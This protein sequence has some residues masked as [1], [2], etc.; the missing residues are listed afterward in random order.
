[1]SAC[2]KHWVSEM[3][4]HTIH[5]NSRKGNGCTHRLYTVVGYRCR[6]LIRYR[7][8]IL[9]YYNSS[10][11]VVSPTCPLVINLLAMSVKLH[12]DKLEIAFSGFHRWV[13]F[14]KFFFKICKFWGDAHL[15]FLKFPGSPFKSLGLTTKT[16]AASFLCFADHLTKYSTC[17]VVSFFIPQIFDII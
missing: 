16:I 10:H 3:K 13:I 4:S 6:T 14:L 15:L 7:I 8:C 5:C 12:V 9:I 2:Q 1:M 17:E 11:S